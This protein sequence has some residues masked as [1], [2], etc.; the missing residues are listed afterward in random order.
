MSTPLHIYT[1]YIGCYVMRI[2]HIIYLIKEKTKGLQ[3][4]K[5]VHLFI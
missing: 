5:T 2:Q 1:I 4:N 3:E